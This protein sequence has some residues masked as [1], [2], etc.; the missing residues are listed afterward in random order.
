MGELS[1]G[2]VCT[3][4][5]QFGRDRGIENKVSVEQPDTA[6]K[7]RF[8]RNGEGHLLHLFDRLVSPRNSLGDAAISDIDIWLWL[9]ETPGEGLGDGECRCLGIPP[10]KR[11]VTRVVAVV[12]GIILIVVAGRWG[13]GGGLGYQI[14]WIRT[15]KTVGGIWSVGGERRRR[16][17]GVNHRCYDVWSN[18]LFL[19]ESGR[20]THVGASRTRQDV[21]PVL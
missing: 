1:F 2:L 21:L 15:I 8:R 17:W 13:E 9:G 20:L 19:F 7:L 14:I 10:Q 16:W 4:I 11:H 18:F 6:I 5:E 3:S 12:C